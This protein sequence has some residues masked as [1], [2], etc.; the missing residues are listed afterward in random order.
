MSGPLT[1]FK[2]DISEQ[3]FSVPTFD[4]NKR[5]GDKTVILRLFDPVDIP[6]GSQV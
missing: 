4:N 6:L 3:T 1:F 5:D 2:D